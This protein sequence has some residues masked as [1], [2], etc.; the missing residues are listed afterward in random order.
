MR[1]VCAAE[2]QETEVLV[3]VV[4]AVREARRHPR[5]HLTDGS[6]RIDDGLPLVVRVLREHAI[7]HGA[8]G[9]IFGAKPP[10]RSEAALLMAHNT[11]RERRSTKNCV[12]VVV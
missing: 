12:V 3:E 10:C 5:G 9:D 4:L 7:V 2:E 1:D 11:P 6:V 8:G